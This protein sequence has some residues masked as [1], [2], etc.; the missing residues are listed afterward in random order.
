MQENNIYLDGIDKEFLE[1]NV[2]YAL[3]L[4]W[5]LSDGKSIDDHVHCVICM[6]PMKENDGIRKYESENEY[7]DVFCFDRFIKKQE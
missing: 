2:E 7:M 6:R 1:G 5:N 3:T 4:E